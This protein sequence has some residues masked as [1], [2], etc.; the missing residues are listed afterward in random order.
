MEHSVFYTVP[1]EVVYDDE[2]GVVSRVVVLDESAEADSDEDSELVAMVND[3]AWP[4]WQ[5]GY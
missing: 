3:A 1:V 2:T 4:A 5:F